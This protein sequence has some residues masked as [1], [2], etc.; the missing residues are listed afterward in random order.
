MKILYRQPEK[1]CNGSLCRFGVQHCYFK[2]LSLDRDRSNITKKDHLHTGF[3]IHIVTDGYQEYKVDEAIYK[4]E[5]G[6]FL[7]IYPNVPHTVITSAPHTQKYSITFSKPTNEQVQCFF[8]PTT[9]RISAN[10]VAISNEALR[11]KEISTALIENNILETIV[12]IFRLSGIKENKSTAK[13]D[14]N[15]TISLAKQ[16]IDDNI[17]MPPSVAN[18]SEHCYLSTKQLTRI[19]DRYEGIS[20]GEYIIKQ[21][22]ERIEHLLIEDALSLKQI[23]E[24]M[25]FSSEYYLSAFFKKHTGLPPGEYRKMFGK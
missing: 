17:E 25:H 5:K 20:P 4:L 3:E 15:A 2:K 7:L 19:F 11:K 24:R 16:Y 14:G 23:G 1:D 9:K 12:L 6:T 10:I 21:R 8:G 22:I 13:Q 18:V